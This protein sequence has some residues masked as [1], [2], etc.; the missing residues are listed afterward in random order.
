MMT[1]GQKIVK[2]M[3]DCSHVGKDGKNAQQNYAY[4]SAVA[5]LERVNRSLCENGLYSSSQIDVIA[6]EMI[7]GGDKGPKRFC[8]IKMK[9]TIHDVDSDKSMTVES[10]GSSLNNGDKG[11]A[12]AQTMALKYAWRNALQISFDDDDPDATENTET[13][14][15]AA[16]SHKTAQVSQPPPAPTKSTF[17]SI[18]DSPT[19]IINS[20]R[21]CKNEEEFHMC[22]TKAK[23]IWGKLTED[24]K[25]EL[26]TVQ[27]SAQK[28]L[29]I[30]FQSRNSA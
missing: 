16:M 4:S 24:M 12:I 26:R 18:H 20:F 2:V 29:G 14:E 8:Q 23:T 22:F 27:A 25:K 9:L 17:V 11:A 1:F 19:T 5:V 7:P 21:T 30:P 28:R 6:D 15:G 3:K 10:L 13:F